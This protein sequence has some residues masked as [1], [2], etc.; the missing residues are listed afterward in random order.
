MGAN[1]F[2]KYI[3]ELCVKYEKKKILLHLLLI[4]LKTEN[5]LERGKMKQHQEPRRG[6]KKPIILIINPRLVKF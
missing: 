2:N 6:G 3:K 1:K 5:H 4:P